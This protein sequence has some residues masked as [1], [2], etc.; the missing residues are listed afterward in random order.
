MINV[1]IFD[2]EGNPGKE[3]ELPKEFHQQV[4]E[5]LIMRA[6]QA[7]NTLDLQ[8]QGHFPLAGMQTT[9]TYYGAMNSY[10]T[11]RHMGVAIR[12]RQKLGGGRQGLV[13]RIPS[14]VKGKRAHP[15]V[16]E[17][18][19]VERMNKKEYNKAIISAISATASVEHVKD[20]KSV[21]I[22]VAKGMESIKQ[23][24]AATALFSKLGLSNYLEECR[25]RKRLKKGASRSSAQR[26]Y[27][28][29]VLVVVAE[30]HGIVKA[31]RNIAGA[32]ACTVSNITAR[33]LAPGGKPGRVT[34][35]SEDAVR[36][37]ASSHMA[38]SLGKK[39]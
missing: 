33:L 18:K 1:K 29:S 31:V 34:V 26:R 20:A 10:R 9:A 17:K 4:R 19:L 6:V 7:E 23:T 13:R 5:D 35:W 39:V 37:V 8:P 15:H 22:V 24:R 14:S 30:D 32:D 12:P 27:K 25:S 16:I 21:P 2:L 38:F 28:K 11:G 3:I 36:A